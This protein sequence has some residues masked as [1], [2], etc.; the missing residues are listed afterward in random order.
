MLRNSFTFQ[1]RRLARHCRRYRNCCSRSAGSS[2]FSATAA[3]WASP[4]SDSASRLSK[5]CPTLVCVRPCGFPMNRDVRTR[6]TT[7]CHTVPSQVCPRDVAPTWR[8]RKVDNFRTWGSNGLCSIGA[9]LGDIPRKTAKHT[10]TF[11][12][13]CMD[14]QRSFLGN[15]QLSP[16]HL[17]S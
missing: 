11:N 3:A 1:R 4:T 5:P 15:L 13:P 14:F 17:L 2:A 9:S 8:Q 10:S 16:H 7:N 6:C 12:I